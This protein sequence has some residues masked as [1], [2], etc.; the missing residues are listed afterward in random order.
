MLLS[1]YIMIHLNLRSTLRARCNQ[2][3]WIPPVLH[4]GTPW[5]ENGQSEEYH[6]RFQV[7]W[8]A[9]ER[10]TCETTYYHIE[11]LFCFVL[12]CLCF[13]SSHCK[14]GLRPWWSSR[15]GN[16][17]HFAL[18]HSCVGREGAIRSELHHGKSLLS[19]LFC[20]TLCCS[21]FIHSFS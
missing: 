13:A 5:L 17:F 6:S 16:P 10:K 12:F 2:H 7:L 1:K 20:S 3:Q 9:Q 4:A 11:A 19:A 18:F 15:D 8:K 14:E 21:T